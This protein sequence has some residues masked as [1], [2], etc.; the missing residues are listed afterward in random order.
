M[1]PLLNPF[2]SMG[3]VESLH[4]TEAHEDWSR[5]RSPARARRRL[6]RG[7]RQNIVHMRR[8]AAFRINGVIYAH[9]EIVR[10]LRAVPERE[11][12]ADG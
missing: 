6:K 8:P 10:Q 3:I 11:G 2:T 12:G 5:V 4:A 1:N 7:F 9:P